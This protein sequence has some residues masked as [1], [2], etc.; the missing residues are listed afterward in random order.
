MNNSAVSSRKRTKILA[1]INIT[2]FTDVVLVLLIIFMVTT[3][4][5]MQS[6]IKVT[7]PKTTRVEAETDRNITITVTAAGE[8]LLNQERVTLEELEPDLTARVASNPNS[9][10]IINGDKDVKYDYII[11]IVDIAQQS[12]VRKFALSTEQKGKGKL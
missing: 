6:G 10:V 1:E 3:P 8:I 11:R 7:L 2:P 9:V 12:G 4:L 5:I